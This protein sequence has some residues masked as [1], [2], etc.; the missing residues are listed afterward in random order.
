MCS[1]TLSYLETTSLVVRPGIQKQLHTLGLPVYAGRCRPIVVSSHPPLL[2]HRPC[3][4]R[5]SIRDHLKP[6]FVIPQN[7]VKQTI[8]GT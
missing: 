7:L 3:E 1:V 6:R 4:P 8:R 2:L 5:H